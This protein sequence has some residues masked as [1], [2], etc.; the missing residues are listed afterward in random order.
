MLED[1][2][3]LLFGAFYFKDTRFYNKARQIIETELEEQILGDGA[4]FELSPMYHQIILDRLLDSIN[5]LQNN[6]RFEAQEQLLDL[7]QKKAQKMLTWINAITFSTGE[8]PLLN[9][10]APGIAPTT[11]QLNKYAT[12]LNF[13]LETRNSKL[14]ASG[15]RKFTT[16]TYECLIDIGQ[17][18]PSYQPGHAHADTFSFVLNVKNEPVLVDTGISTYD[19]SETRL[20]ERGTAAHNTVTVFEKNS[21]EVWSSFRVARRANVKL[22]KDDKNRVIAQHDG[23]KRIGTTHQR[24]WNFEK[25][26]IKIT[27]TL[28][29]KLTEGKAYL[30][31]HSAANPRQNNNTITT[32]NATFAFENEISVKLVP[33]EIPD[34]YNR[35]VKTHKVEIPFKNHLKTIVTQL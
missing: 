27:D 24:E 29:G 14:S 23:Y 20:I 21:S 18:G 34:G 9:D 4:H 8:I 22:L 11:Q 7:M 16:P 33:A 12:S 15:Y 32:K 13:E 3:S 25:K 1:G 28:T 19:A 35:F 5:L 10:S 26:Q 6:Q 31:F 17:I 30:W 2:F